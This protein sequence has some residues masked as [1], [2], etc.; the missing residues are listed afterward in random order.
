MTKSNFREWSL[1]K[2]DEAFGTTEIFE[3]RHLEE[4]L[5]YDAVITP[6]QLEFLE[7]LQK[8]LLLGVEDWNEVELENKFISPVFMLAGIDNVKFAYFLERDLQAVIND[9]ELSGRVDGLIASGYRNPKKPYFCL[10][11]YKKQTD[12]DGSPSGQVLI[13]MLVAQHMNNDGKIIYGSYTIGKFWHFII[14]DG[15][16]YIKSKAFTADDEGLFEIFKIIKGLKYFIEQR[17]K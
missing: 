16:N 3:H 14:L 11:E 1:D 9:C 4:W 5:N 17:V 10:N 13:A 7:Q 2:I 15:K 12:P 8:A 6:Y